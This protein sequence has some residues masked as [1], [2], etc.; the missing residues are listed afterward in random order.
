MTASLYELLGVARAASPAELRAAYRRRVLEVHPDKGGSVELC[1][2]VMAAFEQL[3]DSE[4]RWE[5][6]QSLACSAVQ[7]PP[8]VAVHRR[9][10]G[11]GK[12]GQC[13]ASGRAAQPSRVR[14]RCATAGPSQ[15]SPPDKRRCCGEPPGRAEAA[16]GSRSGKSTHAGGVQQSDAT[17]SH[18]C[19]HTGG[20][21]DGDARPGPASK[22]KAGS[23]SC[24]AGTGGRSGL[25]LHK[26]VELLRCLGQEQRRQFLA[27]G[28]SEPQR[29]ALEAFMRACRDAKGG[30]TASSGRA[31]Q[32]ASNTCGRY[33]RA[34]SGHG[35]AAAPRARQRPSQGAPQPASNTC[36]RYGRAGSGHGMAAAPRARQRLSQGCHCRGPP[37]PWSQ[38]AGRCG[39]LS[40]SG[41]LAPPPLGPAPPTGVDGTEGRLLAPALLA[42]PP[43]L[44]LEDGSASPLGESAS[45]LGGDSGPDAPGAA[46]EGPAELGDAADH[47]QAGKKAGRGV[48]RIQGIVRTSPGK[49]VYYRAQVGF[50]YFMLTTRWR[51]TLDQAID[52]H[53]ALLTLK[54]Q[55]LRGGA[56]AQDVPTEERLQKAIGDMLLTLDDSQAEDLG[57]HVCASMSTCYACLFVGRHLNSPAYGVK[58]L[59]LALRVWRSFRDA[60][61]RLPGQGVS[62]NL[63]DHM[64][65]GAPEVEEMWQ[66]IRQAYLDSWREH[67]ADVKRLAARIDGLAALQTGR[68]QRR[69][70]HLEAARMTRE[71]QCQRRAERRADHRRLAQEAQERRAAELA[72]RRR[73]R[74]ER[75][76]MHRED[77][78]S[79]Y[80]SESTRWTKRLRP[81]S[82]RTVDKAEEERRALR[83]L[84]ALAP[85]WRAR[86]EAEQRRESTGKRRQGARR[87]R[88]EREARRHQD[89][90]GQGVSEPGMTSQGL[91]G[92]HRLPG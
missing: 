65:P 23:C 14:R 90:C 5:Y 21:V 54:R 36:G 78:L 59:G 45:P 12:A 43:P 25:M 82:K 86:L 56:S 81:G 34:G 60:D 46:A 73:E 84:A 61:E 91:C 58:D 4:R 79:R 57:L 20:P 70:E 28:L 7:H 69:W 83:R 64:P 29:L 30:T 3:A 74:E 52:D 66:R 31:P 1:Q 6:D 15:P 11:A 62:R 92:G 55:T 24:P 75:Q 53:V 51:H 32:P 16:A 39:G 89:A 22:P 85:R 13:T 72:R 37:R 35:M 8:A 47:A 50:S 38:A 19:A 68:R 77:V 40:P 17:G 33:G 87:Q 80:I 42:L 48:A 71:E 41:G 26:V 49:Y 67:G 10:A 44:P 2:A 27:R 18:G 63:L 88:E 9:S 76:R